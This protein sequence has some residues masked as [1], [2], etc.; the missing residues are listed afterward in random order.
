MALV[1]ESAQE[2]DSECLGRRS[3]G[4]LKTGGLLP[5]VESVSSGNVGS[6]RAG[7]SVGS[8]F[9]AIS[10]TSSLDLQEPK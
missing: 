3:L 10:I 5:A 6:G 8:S 7:F 4:Y 9:S 2:P 1:L